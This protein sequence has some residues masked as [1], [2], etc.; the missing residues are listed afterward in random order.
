MRTFTNS[1][2]ADM[3]RDVAVALRMRGA[4]RFQ[5]V[6]YERAA[7]GVETHPDSLARMW[8]AGRLRDVAGVGGSITQHLDELFR[9][10]RV[11]YW[12]EMTAGIPDVIFELLRVPGVGQVTAWKLARAGVEDLEDL[13][14]QIESGRL[15]EA[16]FGQK[17][18]TTIAAGLAELN[19]R[20][21]RMLL[22]AAESLA[23]PLLEAL[24]TTAG[25]ERA[26]VLGSLRRRAPTLGN[27]NLA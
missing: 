11:A 25:V 5:P 23:A 19:R 27:V 6:A 7:H 18:L 24:H 21:D 8:E 15:A 2:I 1:E 26:D 12:D 16:G 22:P 14:R 10:G 9:T 4:E 20:P 17:Q 3:L 13:E